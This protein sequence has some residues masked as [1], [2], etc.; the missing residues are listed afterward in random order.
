MHELHVGNGRAGA[1]RHGHAVA[2][3]NFRVGGVPVN[4]TQPAC[5]Q[6]RCAGEELFHHALAN[7]QHVRAETVN[8]FGPAL[9]FGA[10]V[11]LGDQIHGHVVFVHVDVGVLSDGC[12]QRPFHLPAGQILRVHDSVPRVTSLAPQFEKNALPLLSLGEAYAPVLE[13]VHANRPLA[14]H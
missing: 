12:N 14:N 7:V 5:R 1:V 11:V 9:L 8:P 10:Q 2:G 4:L 13:L 6:Q 3:G